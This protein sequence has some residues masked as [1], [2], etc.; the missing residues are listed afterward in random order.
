MANDHAPRMSTRE[1]FRYLDESAEAITAAD[2]QH[3][4]TDLMHK[5]PGDPRADDLTETLY[6]HQEQLA[7]RKNTLRVETGRILNEHAD[8][9]GG[10]TA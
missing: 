8:H 6:M 4:R 7:A 3:L 2:V 10:R 9:G 5:W 1:Y